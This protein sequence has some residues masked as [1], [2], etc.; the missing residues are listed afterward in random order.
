[1]SMRVKILREAHEDILYGKRF[2]DA[3]ELGVGSYF[4]RTIHT[5]IRSLKNFAGT[6]PVRQ[7]YHMLLVR[8]FPYAIYY[9]KQGDDVTVVAVLDCRRNPEYT[10]ARL[11]LYQ[12]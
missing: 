2:Y 7:G 5:E 9:D 11:G 3:Q 8:R 10:A 1:M 4:A 6:H 12:G